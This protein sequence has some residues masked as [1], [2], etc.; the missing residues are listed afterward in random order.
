MNVAYVVKRFPRVSETFVLQEV[1][2]LIRQ[3]ERV[4]V[5]SLRRPNADDPVHPGAEDLSGRTVYLP[6]GAARTLR[7]A[8]AAAAVVGAAPRPAA[9]ALAWAVGRALRDREPGYLARF[10]EAAYLRMR[11]PHDLD[12]VHAHFANEPAT[13][14]LLL[15]RLTGRPFSFTA[16]AYEIFQPRTLDLRAKLAEARF[17]VAVSEY[18]RRHLASVG[19]S[20][21]ASK[22][23]VVRNGVDRRRFRPRE[24]DR[25]GL[26]LLIAVSRLVAKKGLDTVIEACALLSA[27][28]VDF[29]CE[30]VGDGHLRAVLEALAEDRAVSDRVA[31]VGSHRQPAVAEA[32]A[33]AT[34]FVLPCRRTESGDQDAL[35]VAI[36][37]SMTAG[38]PVVTTPVGGIPEVVHDGESGLLVQPDD[39]R[40]LADALERLLRD[41]TLR[42]RLA[43]G[44]RRAVAEFDLSESVRRL[45]RLFRDGPSAELEG[46]P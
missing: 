21:N 32:F 33:R 39:S 46:S 34:A 24:A 17:A 10:A 6:E 36:T 13:V 37:E 27:R 45:R 40:A 19:G 11:L 2:E 43:E 4:T 28:G 8:A 44:G 9:S 41:G 20:K 42:R 30:I 1:Q 3:G 23:V 7:L 31:F 14:A 26:P 12:H 29:R 18:S 35:P 22:V 16:H 38:V 15:G 5:C 25:D